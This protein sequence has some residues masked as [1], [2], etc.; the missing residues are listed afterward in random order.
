MGCRAGSAVRV[1]RRVATSTRAAACGR[2][3]M[4][5][6]DAKGQCS[7]LHLRECVAFA[8]RSEA[9]SVA[10]DNIEAGDVFFVFCAGFGLSV[11]ACVEY[12][13]E[14]IGKESL[15]TCAGLFR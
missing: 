10:K 2:E 13:C 4:R 11:D 9:F 15:E 5:P 7:F 3:T 6:S 1:L 8:G 14:V 12:L